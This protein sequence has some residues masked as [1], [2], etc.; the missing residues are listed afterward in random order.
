M[1]LQRIVFVTVEL[2]SEEFKIWVVTDK[3]ER[4]KEKKL[5]YANRYGADNINFLW[6]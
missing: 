3:N 2:I 4:G 5:P 1:S 6:T